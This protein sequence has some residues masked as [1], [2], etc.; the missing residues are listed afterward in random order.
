MSNEMKQ[1]AESNELVTAKQLAKIWGISK[2]GAQKRL[3]KIGAVPEIE[4]DIAR[5]V[6]AK[7]N[8]STVDTLYAR[9][10]QQ[11]QQSIHDQA[12]QK[13]VDSLPEEVKVK[14]VSEELQKLNKRNDKW[15]IEQ[16]IGISL[17]MQSNLA[18]RLTQ[19]QS[20]IETKD[21][22]ILRLKA[23]IKD[24]KERWTIAQFNHKVCEGKLSAYGCSSLGKI[25][26]LQCKQKGIKIHKVELMKGTKFGSVGC[27]PIAEFDFWKTAYE[28]GSL[29]FLYKSTDSKVVDLEDPDFADKPDADAVDI[30]DIVDEDAINE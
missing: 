30:C 20:E 13:K 3:N 26:T 19:M 27:Y 12:I 10:L 4:A 6:P 23:K 25:L 21:G 15:A 9:I 28:E 29:D 22:K 17:M 5:G 14:T 18:K 8:K 2:D 11:Q 24:I 7:Y 1:L 16:E